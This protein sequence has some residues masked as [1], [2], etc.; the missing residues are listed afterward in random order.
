MSSKSIQNAHGRRP[1][2]LSTPAD[3]LVYT[4]GVSEIP[5][6]VSGG[7]TGADR[8]ALDCAIACRVP[9]GGWC[10]KGRKAEDGDI[11]TS[12]QLKETPNHNHVQ[13][14]DWNVRDSI[15]LQT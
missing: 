4:V 3:W 2:F 9:H 12:Y 5:E 14:T 15:A 13:R 10:P 1:H 6:L 7:Q 8:A 11:S